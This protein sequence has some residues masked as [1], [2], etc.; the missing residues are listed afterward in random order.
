MLI[1]DSIE[2]EIMFKRT[3]MFLVMLAAVVTVAFAHGDFTH[4]TGTITAIEGD[5]VQ[6]KDL[7]GKSVMVMLQKTT[8]YLKAEKATTKSELKVGTRV[9]VD[10]TMDDKMKMFAAAEI[11][12][13]VTTPAAAT[14]AKPASTGK[15]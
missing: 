10:A 1:T 7:Q 6:I 15:K 3:C 4:I 12:I 11:A 8:K 9:K 13:G 2:G 14:P 5:H